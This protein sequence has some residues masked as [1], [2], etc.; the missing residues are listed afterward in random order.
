MVRNLWKRI[1][2]SIFI[3]F[4]L[5][6]FVFFLSN[7]MKGNAV[8]ALL[9][10]NPRMSQETY[11]A[12]LEARGLNLPIPVRYWHWLSA[13]LQGDLG[14]CTQFNVPVASIIGQRL[15]P[16][17]ILNFTALLLSII[18]SI[19]LGIM[20]AYKPYSA[21]DNVSSVLSFIGASLPSFLM[22]LLGIYVFAVKLHW[23]PTQGMYFAN[24][25]Q[26]LG[27]LAIHLVLPATIGAFQMVGSLLKQTRGAMLEVLSEDYIK[28]ARSK[29]LK[30]HAVVIAHGLRNALIPIV[31]TIGLEIPYLV[32][33]SVVLE[34]IFSWPGI[35]SFLITSINARDYD[36]I[37]GISVIICL[38]VLATNIVLDLL[39]MVIDPRMAKEG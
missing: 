17:L 5:T 22:G 25:P 15:G 12:I 10:A 21:W 37:M 6:F 32:S 3:F 4:V 24:Q 26:T 29:G 33:G 27:N 23:L 11:N 28:T 14:T 13:F 7:M 35:G 1:L 30:E 34:T 38:V 16:T 20:A 36:P 8:D 2:F 39:Y 9:A 18:I 19:P 31:T